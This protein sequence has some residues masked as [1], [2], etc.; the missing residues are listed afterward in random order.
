MF[1]SD[2]M[3]WVMEGIRRGLSGR[4]RR[5]QRLIVE[6]QDAGSGE[7]SRVMTAASMEEALARMDQEATW[8]GRDV[9][10]RVRAERSAWVPR[11]LIGAVVL[12]VSIAVAVVVLLRT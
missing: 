1:N 6:K 3:P 5:S 4:Q 10:F 8:S 2:R 11:I 9:Q 7:W 12:L